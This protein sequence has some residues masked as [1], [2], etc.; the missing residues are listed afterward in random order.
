MERNEKGQFARGNIPWNRGLRGTHLSPGSEFK[1]GQIPANKGKFHPY[2][3][4][5]KKGEHASSSTEWKKGVHPSP[6]TEFT[7]ERVKSWFN[8]PEMKNKIVAGILRGKF[9]RPTKPELK[10]MK[11][12]KQNSLPFKYVGDGSK[13]ISGFCPDFIN[14]EKKIIVEIFGDYW[15]RRPEVQKRDKQRLK[16]FHKLGWKP[17]VIWASELGTEGFDI[18]LERRLFG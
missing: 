4:K 8:D 2:G 14:K 3:H 10:F 17:V 11:V 7:S 9:K 12:I 15:H 5:W 6:R 16:V 1:K 13:I 18:D